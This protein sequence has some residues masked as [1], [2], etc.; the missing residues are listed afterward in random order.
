MPAQDIFHDAVKNALI[1]EGWTITDDPLY[2]EFGGVDMYVDLGS[3]KL[4]GA[5][6]DLQKLFI[7]QAKKQKIENGFQKCL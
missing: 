7:T 2:I 5:E 3:E 1:K 6:S 4:V